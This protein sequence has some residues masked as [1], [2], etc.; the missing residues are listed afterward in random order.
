M[1]K[2]KISKIFA[3]LIVISMIMSLLPTQ[4]V[5]VA[6]A[7]DPADYSKYGASVE[8]M[9]AS[10]YKGHVFQLKEVEGTNHN[11]ELSIGAYNMDQVSMYEAAFMY[12]SDAVDLQFPG[13]SADYP[14]K[15]N[16]ENTPISMYYTVGN[17]TESMVN[18]TNP[19]AKGY[20]GK[21][22]A[23]D[24]NYVFGNGVNAIVTQ[25]GKYIKVYIYA[26]ANKSANKSFWT[27]SGS[28][29]ILEHKDNYTGDT[30]G[31]K[32]PE[33]EL[34]NIFNFELKL[35]SGYSLTSDTIKIY[36]TENLGF[37]GARGV[38]EV[39]NSGTSGDTHTEAHNEGVYFIGFQEPEVAPVNVNFT[40]IKNS[41]NE[42]L[43]QADVTLYTD[44]AMTQVATTKDGTELKGQTD[45]N[46]ALI[47]QN[48]PANKTY[49]YKITKDGYETSQDATTNKI[50]VGI[51]N[52]TV[53][54]VEM[55]KASEATHP[56]EIT[57]IDA[58]TD[59]GL[60]GATVKL[61]GTA[62]DGTTGA[63]G[64]I[65][66]AKIVGTY[67]VEVSKAGYQNA[68]GSVTVNSAG[69]STTIKITPERVTLNL[70]TVKDG[71]GDTVATPAVSIKKTAGSETKAWQNRTITDGSTTVAVP[72][73]STFE[74]EFSMT[75][76]SSY[77]LYAKTDGS[78]ATLYKDE[79]CTQAF[80]PGTDEVTIEKMGDPFYDVKI[81]PDS[82]DAT[83]KTY[84]AAVT[85][86]NIKAVYGTFGIRYD[87]DV[88]TLD[89]DNGFTLASELK[90][91][92]PNNGVEGSPMADKQVTTHKTTDT[93]GYHVFS[94]AKSD[95]SST[96]SGE[97]TEVGNGT[98][99]DTTSAGKLVATYKFTLNDGKTAEDI[100]SDAF[101]VMPYDKTSAAAQF[102]DGIDKDDPLQVEETKWY[103][104]QLW[105]YV[106][107]ENDDPL[108]EGRLARDKASDDGFYQVHEDNT[109]EMFDVMTVFHFEA[110]ETV[111]VFEAVDD[112]H[113]A[114]EDVTIVVTGPDGEPI[115]LT[116]DSTGIAKMLVDTTSGPVTY[117][118][119]ATR[120][121]YWDIPETSVTVKANTP[122]TTTI[123]YITMH[124]KVYHPTKLKDSTSTDAIESRP[125]VQNASLRGDAFAYNGRDYHFNIKPDPG[126]EFD[127][128]AAGNVVA[129]VKN[130]LSGE[131]E[132]HNV[133]YNAND[134][135]YVLAGSEVVG[136]KLDPQNPDENG[137][138]SDDIYIVVDPAS[139]TPS[140][141][142]FKV[143]AFAGA[144]GTVTYEETPEIGSQTVDKSVTNKVTVSN[145][146][147]KESTNNFTFTATDN[148]YTIEKVI[149]NGVV[150]NTYNG[151][152]TLEYKFENI[153]E[154]C[155]IAVM[156]TDG[157]TPSTESMIT[158]VVAGKGK[159]DTSDPSPAVTDIRD[160]RSVFNF[161]N[162]GSVTFTA[163]PDSGVSGPVVEK[164]V[165]DGE[166]TA[167][168]PTGSNY[169][170]TSE[171]GENVVVYV[172]FGT[173]TVFVKAYVHEGQGTISPVGELIYNKYDSPTFTMTAANTKWKLTGVMLDGT[174]EYSYPTQ[175]ATGTYQ[176]QSLTE[177]TSIG[178]IFSATT[179]RVYGVIDFSEGKSPLNTKALFSHTGAKIQFINEL[180]P[181]NI[182][183]GHD[184]TDSRTD[185][186]FEVS[187]PEGRWTLVVSKRGYLNYRLTGITITED[188]PEIYLG[189][190]DNTSETMKKITPLI[191]NTSGNGLVVALN[192]AGVISTGFR[193]TNAAIIKKGDVADDD[194]K[195]TVSDLSFVK[196]NYAKR[197]T[198]KTYADFCAGN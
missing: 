49:Y 113:F 5:S 165:N 188:K 110:K 191:G 173:S 162:G 37:C 96:A 76:Y 103:M 4:F 42:G 20:A 124:E 33:D 3:A 54:E 185:S 22:L 32:F 6:A 50:D 61:E 39:Y 181:T 118:Y 146:A 161:E 131:Y 81:E 145:I 24:G 43:Y 149:I 89:A 25:D 111:L 184:S 136:T 148:G 63:G 91:Y 135:V 90:L 83:G 29:A 7:K 134:D 157:K 36:D 116:T 10:G 11:L 2:K 108:G 147:A 95:D 180:D 160:K 123:E 52:V 97:D 64:K 138:K 41:S 176:L 38:C 19:I 114:I 125:D 198:R 187:V 69:G 163:T 164:K 172:S 93:V 150:V 74:L 192:D 99:F 154:D 55:T 169:T 80:T 79:A 126:Y 194:G 105:R 65:S 175:L 186:K 143:E 190:P 158:L 195:A 179:Y 18:S 47:I 100:A 45:N 23:S 128:A 117:N 16:D 122:P 27:N 86:N 153:T 85:L 13:D 171:P 182:I 53:P 109:G 178:A 166:A 73:D 88:F 112:N 57:V 60:D 56:V 193:T 51:S 189:S 87:K 137:F 141:K 59:T 17:T 174:N 177:D 151:Q 156:F 62:I 133:T 58:D 130:V 35:K 152:T 159:V 66:T 132:P 9:K 92:D 107:T 8:E 67:V 28:G 15:C 71:N 72:K 104:D 31:Y 78:T 77:K 155:S 140:T 40:K 196:K 144:H 139:I 82:S 1:V 21:S 48:V 26:M 68:K 44:S 14:F 115:T 106:D 75:G 12:D 120:P 84:T 129:Y 167:V 168:T 121:G 70:P 183:T 142:K 94:W 127:Q 30:V 98:A 34:C 101:A 170:V 46:G 197:Q 102:I 119:T